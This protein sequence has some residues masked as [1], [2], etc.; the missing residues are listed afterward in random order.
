VFNWIILCAF[1]V[2]KQSKLVGRFS[3]VGF[4]VGFMFLSIGSF[5]FCFFLG[6][7]GPKVENTLIYKVQ[8]ESSSKRKM[9]KS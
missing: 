9:N 3:T 7:L 6:W 4:I 1:K 2:D 8:I 5:Y